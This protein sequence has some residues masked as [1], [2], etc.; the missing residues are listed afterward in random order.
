VCDEL[1]QMPPLGTSLGSAPE[2]GF[3]QRHLPKLTTI[4]KEQERRLAFSTLSSYTVRIERHRSGAPSLSPAIIESYERNR[5]SA[6]LWITDCAQSAMLYFGC[7]IAP[8]KPEVISPRVYKRHRRIV[9]AAS[10]KLRI[11]E[12]EVVRRAI[13]AFSF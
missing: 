3:T 13:E 1:G 11:S 12:A 10:K 9:K 5:A 2:L 8:E 6:G 4:F 7:M